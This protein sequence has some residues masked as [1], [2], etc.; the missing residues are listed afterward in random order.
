MSLCLLRQI[1]PGFESDLLNFFLG[2]LTVQLMKINLKLSIIA[3]IFC[4]CFIALRFKLDSRSQIRTL[5]AEDHVNIEIDAANEGETGADHNQSQSDLQSNHSDDHRQIPFL[6]DG[7]NWKK[8]VDKVVKGS[9]NQI[10]YYKCTYPNCFVEKKVERTKDGE[11][12]E[13]YY[14]GTHSHHKAKHSMKRNSSHEYLYSLLPSESDTTY[15][16]DQ[17]SA[18]Q[19]GGQLNYDVQHRKKYSNEI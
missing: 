18:F 5:G 10:S 15:L 17:S 9:E 6:S 14:Q 3:A 12:I 19:G 2:C 8:I 1:G 11:I 7:Y 16:Q 13:I 4:Y